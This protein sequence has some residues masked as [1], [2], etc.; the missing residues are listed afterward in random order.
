MRKHARVLLAIATMLILLPAAFWSSASSDEVVE[1]VQ[2]RYNGLS[3]ISAKFRQLSV[4]KASMLREQSWGKVYISKPGKMRWEYEE[5]ERRLIV[6]D[7]NKVWTYL[8]EQ[9]QVY[10]A[11]LNE[12]YITRTPLAFLVGKGKLKEE[13]E[14][15]SSPVKDEQRGLIFR[16]DLRP[17]K[18]QM[19]LSRLVLEVDGESYLIVKS[20]LYDSMGNLISIKFD[21][22]LIDLD[23]PQ[24]LFQFSPPK[25]VEV[26][27]LGE[28][29]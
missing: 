12:A 24:H 7:G 5:P 20:D 21:Q 27:E 16:L 26:V 28:G 10:V 8:P 23:L 11:R 18:P 2:A 22:I 14:I 3:T 6:S 29:G 17:H 25:S 19:N 13:F 1:M 4:N 15:V 9:N